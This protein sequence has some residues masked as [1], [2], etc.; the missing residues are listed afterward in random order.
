MAK[1]K[2]LENDGLDVH[3]G[4][5]QNY[6]SGIWQRYVSYI[7]NMPDNWYPLDNQIFWKNDKLTREDY[8]T[9]VLPYSLQPGSI[10]NYDYLMGTLY[11]QSERDKLE[12]AIGAILT[13]DSRH[14]QKFITLYGSAGSGKSTFLNIVQKLV[15]GYYIS[16]N[17]KDLVGRDAFGM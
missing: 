3:Y 17:A 11:N 10:T 6:E 14:I 4:L 12:W 1:V 2:E 8:A 13:G 7:K 9:R 15:S 5:M 16:F